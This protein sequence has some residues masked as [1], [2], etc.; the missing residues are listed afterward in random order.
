MKRIF[1]S[2][3]IGAS[4]MFLAG[5]CL[6]ANPPQPVP[7]AGGLRYGAPP[8]N[9]GNGVNANQRA[10]QAAAAAQRAAAAQAARNNA[11]AARNAA[12]VQRYRNN[13]YY[14]PYGSSGYAPYGYSGY[15]PYGYS[16]PPY[17]YL[18]PGTTPYILGY[19]PATGAMFLVPYGGGYSPYYPQSGYQYSNFDNS[20]LGYGYPSA[21]FA[22]AGQ[23]Y[24]LGPIQQLM[25]VSQWF[26]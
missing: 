25:G 10:A 5:L 7:P 3:G 13:G 24:G 12:N 8:N 15:N 16:Y 21:V 6:A 18:P 23:L 26:Q 9:G 17:G 4:V 2:M 19:N 14:S 20:Y 22:N 11:A 1:V